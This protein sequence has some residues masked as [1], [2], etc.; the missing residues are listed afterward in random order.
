M[1]FG[2]FETSRAVTVAVFLLSIFVIP[3]A[4]QTELPLL[5]LQLRWTHQAQF[6]GYYVARELGFYKGE[7]IDIEIAPGGTYADPMTV[8]ALDAT[9]VAIGWITS[10][11]SAR[12]AGAE[13]IN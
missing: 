5:K 13:V 8:L 1:T 9:D 6:A 11:I 4:A 7:G 2:R 3:A 12:Q 10:A